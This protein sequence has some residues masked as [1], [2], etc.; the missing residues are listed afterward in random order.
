[1]GKIEDEDCRVFNRV[2]KGGIGDDIGRECDVGQV[3]DVLVKMID[4][5]CELVLL[6]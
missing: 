4:Q 5:C 1:M 6:G 3:F 2:L